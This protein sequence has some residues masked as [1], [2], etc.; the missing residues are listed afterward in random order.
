MALDRTA[1]HIELWFRDLGH[2]LC[3]AAFALFVLFCVIGGLFVLVSV[4]LIIA[5]YN[6]QE[7]RG[8]REMKREAEAAAVRKAAQEE[9]LKKWRESLATFPVGKISEHEI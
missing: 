8:M 5:E 2:N 4:G 7:K 9:R 3:L 6:S 1:S